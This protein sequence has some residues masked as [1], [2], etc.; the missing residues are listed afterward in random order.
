M[1]SVEAPGIK[2]NEL[3]AFEPRR[4]CRNYTIMLALS[5][6]EDRSF[7]HQGEYG[8]HYPKSAIV[9]L[10]DRVR[11]GDGWG[12]KYGN[13]IAR[14]RAVHQAFER[15]TG[16]WSV[17]FRLRQAVRQG[18][19]AL[20]SPAVGWLIDLNGSRV[21]LLVA[22]PVTSVLVLKGFVRERGRAIAYVELDMPVA[23]M[24]FVPLTQMF[25]DWWGWETTWIVLSAIGLGVIVPLTA[26][27]VRRHPEDIGLPP[28][29]DYLHRYPNGEAVQ[30]GSEVRNSVSADARRLKA[31][32]GNCLCRQLKITDYNRNRRALRSV[33]FVTQ[34]ARSLLFNRPL[35]PPLKH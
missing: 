31:G 20:T 15:L 17:V 26:I 7:K 34:P 27:L 5:R 4:A 24:I 18:S 10:G 22:A 1:A 13:G 6:V 29:G 32:L 35:A 12:G 2:N 30:R 9:L 8:K 16:H 3:S 21:L 23:A 11:D 14:F 33:Q 19:S 25:I 28:E